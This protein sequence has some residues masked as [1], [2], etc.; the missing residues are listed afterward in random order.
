[1]SAKSTFLFGGS[2]LSVTEYINSLSVIDFFF[3]C[4]FGRKCVQGVT[5]VILLSFSIGSRM[6]KGKQSKCIGTAQ[7]V[8]FKVYQLSTH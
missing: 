4:L 2:L 7:L 6:V 5:Y 3:T 1:M 8:I